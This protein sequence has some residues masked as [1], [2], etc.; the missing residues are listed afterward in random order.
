MN[1]FTI[2]EQSIYTIKNDIISR[3]AQTQEQTQYITVIY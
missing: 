2:I 1:I 3:M